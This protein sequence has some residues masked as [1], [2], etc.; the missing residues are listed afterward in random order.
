M[1]RLSLPVLLVLCWSAL[2]GAA[3]DVEAIRADAKF[4]TEAS[5]SRLKPGVS[6]QDL[7]GFKSDL[8]KTVA[9]GMLEGTYD[10]A[11]RTA[12]YEAYPSPSELGRTLKLG[13]VEGGAGVAS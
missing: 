11:Y 1:K 8:L 13:D 2:C 5:C 6:T 9:A 3:Y 10:A 12:T 4:F 7:A